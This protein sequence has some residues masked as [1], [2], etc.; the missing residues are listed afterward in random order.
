MGADP[1]GGPESGQGKGD[2]RGLAKIIAA[3]NHL[4]DLDFG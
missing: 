3:S 1:I 4:N 2:G